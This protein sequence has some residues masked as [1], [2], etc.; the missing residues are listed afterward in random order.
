MQTTGQHRRLTTVVLSIMI[1]SVRVPQEFIDHARRVGSTPLFAE[2]TYINWSKRGLT[3]QQILDKITRH[4][5][6]AKATRV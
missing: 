1:E 4:G 6:Q 2:L 3:R 5:E